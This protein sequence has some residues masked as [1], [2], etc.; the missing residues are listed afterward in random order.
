[1][2]SNEVSD[3]YCRVTGYHASVTFLA[4]LDSEGAVIA[5]TFHLLII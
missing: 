3:Q 2:V 4:R 1:M 5:S